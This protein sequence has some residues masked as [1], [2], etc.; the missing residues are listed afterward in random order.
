[1]IFYLFSI[2]FL[3]PRFGMVPWILC[4]LVGQIVAAAAIDHFGLLGSPQRPIDLIRG[5][6]II[7]MFS[8]L[9]IVVRPPSA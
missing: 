1:M 3:V 9:A 6:G 2:S 7:L 8:G 5:V 4:V